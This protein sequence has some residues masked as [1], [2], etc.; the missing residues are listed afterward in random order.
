MKKVIS[1]LVF[2]TIN[3]PILFAQKQF[4]MTCHLNGFADGEKFIL[5]I[6]A[7]GDTIFATLKNSV[8]IFRGRLQETPHFCYL[9]RISKKEETPIELFIGNT[10]VYIRT[11]K[12]IWP[13]AK[14]V[15]SKSHLD[16]LAYKTFIQSTNPKAEGDVEKLSKLNLTYSIEHPTSFF[17]PYLLIG[18]F[19]NAIVSKSPE[20]VIDSV[21]LGYNKLSPLVKKST[22]GIDLYRRLDDRARLSMGKIAPAFTANTPDNISISL[23]QVV[24]QSKV[25]LVDFWASW[26]HVCR[27]ETPNII[28]IYNAFHE[29]GFNVISVSMDQKFEPWNNAIFSD[30]MSWINVSDLKGFAS[31]IAK[32]YALNDLPSSYLLD[33]EGKIIAKNLRDTIL[34]KKVKEILIK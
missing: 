1:C 6:P 12:T 16:F 13:D 33:S 14:V 10:S 23:K 8:A 29:K 24:A 2:L 15:G 26:C 27:E 21:W 18:V 32:A 4:T 17:S 20:R 5:T 34:E 11:N 3:I 19:V 31:P 25:T 28:R 9:G 30:K 7:S 22:Y